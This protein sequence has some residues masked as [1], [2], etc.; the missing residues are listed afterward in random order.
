MH[1]KV[2]ILICKK[3]NMKQFWCTKLKQPIICIYIKNLISMSNTDIFKFDISIF[4][5]YL[6]FL[7]VEDPNW[8]RTVLHIHNTNF[9]KNISL[10]W[11][12]K[13]PKITLNLIP[14]FFTCLR[15]HNLFWEKIHLLYSIYNLKK[16]LE[17]N[18]ILLK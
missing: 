9:N 12:K 17:I 14:W 5:Y 2:L 1:V 4:C 7:Q 8:K 6:H 3:L 13:I 18:L 15:I 10:Y 11:S 16:N